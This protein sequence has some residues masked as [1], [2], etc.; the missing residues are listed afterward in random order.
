MRP[1]LLLLLLLLALPQATCRR[2]VAAAGGGGSV[3]GSSSDLLMGLI[4]T[5]DCRSGGAARLT[6]AAGQAAHCRGRC[7]Q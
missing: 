7:N 1:L 5:L 3:G 4:K 2:R 6:C